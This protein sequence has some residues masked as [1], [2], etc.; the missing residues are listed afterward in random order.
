M[1]H[2]IGPDGRRSDFRPTPWLPAPLH[3]APALLRLKY[4]TLRDKLA[5]ARA[6]LRL[7]RGTAKKGSG[8]IVLDW[9]RD[10]R[11]SDRSIERF[12]KIVLESA[13][14]ESLDR[15]SLAAARKVFLDGFLGHSAA[16]HVLVPRVSLGELYDQVAARLAEAG[17]QICLEA[18]VKRIEQSVTNSKLAVHVATRPEDAV[19]RA[20][21]DFVILAVPWDQCAGLIAPELLGRLPHLAAARFQAA[22]ITSVHLWFDRPITTL[23]H[24]VLV[25][26]LSQWVFRRTDFQSVRN[27]SDQ[28][29]RIRNPSYYQ[30]VISASHALSVQPREAIR[31]QVL[32]DLAAVFPAARIATLRRW[33]IIHDQDAVFS[34]RPG[35][36]DLRPPQATPIPNLFLAGDWT[37]TGWPATMEGAVRSGYLAAEALL[38]R[39]GR[40][41]Q[42]L[43]PDL[44]RCWMLQLLA[45][46]Q[47]A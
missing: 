31:D 9:L 38:S 30:V 2:F 12:W 20:E 29:G 28:P 44:M 35:S 21:F 23:A 34:C 3:L 15:A 7:V 19:S 41:E 1:L 14:A 13:L 32:A 26:R 25:G 39:L 24:A 16:C 43:V 5:I 46:T 10:E 18:S 6:M 4:L 45:G 17:V 37:R 42:L 27:E 40:P 22:P 11:Q 36:D 47:T 8:L 33:Q